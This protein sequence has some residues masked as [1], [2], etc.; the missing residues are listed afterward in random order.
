MGNWD[1]AGIW[2]SVTVKVRIT[3]DDKRNRHRNRTPLN[4]NM[5]KILN[6]VKSY[7]LITKQSAI[8]S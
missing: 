4:V 8:K 6:S 7:F 1:C 3:T 5:Y 2:V